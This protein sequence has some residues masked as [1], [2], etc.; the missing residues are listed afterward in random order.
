M[1]TTGPRA[2][3]EIVLEKKDDFARHATEQL[4]AY[5]LGR[6][7][8]YHDQAELEAIFTRMKA[9][10]YRLNTLVKEIATSYAFRHRKNAER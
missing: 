1:A 3:K 8:E 10:E 5:A 2:L 7:V 6:E 9:D 4:F